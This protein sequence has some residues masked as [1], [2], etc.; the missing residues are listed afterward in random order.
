MHGAEALRRYF[1]EYEKDAR[2]V[3]PK[4]GLFTDLRFSLGSPEEAFPATEAE[5]AEI[6]RAAK[7]K[8]EWLKAPNGNPSELTPEQW[9]TVRTRAFKEWFGDWEKAAR[10]EKLRDSVP[11][12]ISGR[13]IEEGADIKSYRKNAKEYGSRLRGTYLN[14]D[15]G[16]RIAISMSGINEV[17]SHDASPSQFKSIAA[18]PQMVENGIYIESR[19]NEDIKKHPDVGSY[20]YFVCGLKIGGADYTAKIVVAN[21]RNGGTLLRPQTYTNREGRIAFNV[22][23]HTQGR[24]RKQHAL[25]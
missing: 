22:V 14:R 23:R 4:T 24:G 1:A 11:V 19:E 18:I 2:L 21:Q 5:R 15:T 16:K 3:L 20:D 7:A 8:G 10:I 12:E 9:V 25:V 13:E 6:E 17:L